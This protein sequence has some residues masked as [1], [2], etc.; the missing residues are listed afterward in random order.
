MDL[1]EEN[2]LGDR[3]NTHW[4]YVS[5]GRALLS[6]IKNIKPRSVLDVGAG[7]GV[8]SRL[9]LDKTACAS[10]VCV[11]PNYFLGGRVDEFT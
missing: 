2:I 10:A 11:D 3:I 4:Y 8:F 7:S 9:L 1:L 5:K 6:F